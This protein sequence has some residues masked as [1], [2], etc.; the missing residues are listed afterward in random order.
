LID[1]LG[2]IAAL[3]G[4]RAEQIKTVGM[5]GAARREF[6]DCSALGSHDGALLPHGLSG[7]A[8]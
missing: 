7:T 1:R 6:A 4:D 5:I 3:K 8:I 2:I